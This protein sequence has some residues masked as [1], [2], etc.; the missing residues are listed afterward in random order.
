MLIAGGNGGVILLKQIK[1]ISLEFL[2]LIILCIL[3]SWI[4]HIT[5]ILASN[6]NPKAFIVNYF[7]YLTFYFILG[8]FINLISKKI[9]LKSVKFNA[10]YFIMFLISAF[11]LLSI[12]L[13]YKYL[14]N[15]IVINFNN[16]NYIISF[17]AGANF[18]SA[19]FGSKLESY[20]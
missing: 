5:S 6:L 18:C 19:I 2:G 14:P 20:D 7:L 3:I 13:F 15:L 12:W 11:L 4:K 10:L 9:P 16:I 8:G 17:Y 1:R